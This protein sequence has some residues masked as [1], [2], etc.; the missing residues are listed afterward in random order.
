VGGRERD[1]QMRNKC[2]LLQKEE[3]KGSMKIER[4]S[5]EVESFRFDE[6]VECRK[7]KRLIKR[8]IALWDCRE[9]ERR[10]KG[11]SAPL[12]KSSFEE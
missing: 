8:E 3:T 5:K 6:C 2:Q 10:E 7:T 11:C 1:V 4:G 12:A 9:R